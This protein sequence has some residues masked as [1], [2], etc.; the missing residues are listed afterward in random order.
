MT[1][2]SVPDVQPTPP[3]DGDNA[4]GSPDDFVSAINAIMPPGLQLMTATCLSV[5][6]ERAE[7]QM[8]YEL[9]ERFVNVSHLRRLHCPDPRPD[10]HRG[11]IGHDRDAVLDHRPARQ[12]CGRGAAGKACRDRL[13]GTYDKLPRL[14]RSPGD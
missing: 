8:S 1:H 5:C 12:L 10:R 14:H 9:D 13:G 11:S 3:P 7:V 2:S 6:R 4:G